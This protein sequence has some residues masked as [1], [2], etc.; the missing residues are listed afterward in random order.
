MLHTRNYAEQMQMK[1][2]KTHALW[3]LDL[4]TKRVHITLLNKKPQDE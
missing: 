3:K 1:S 2:Y 4:R